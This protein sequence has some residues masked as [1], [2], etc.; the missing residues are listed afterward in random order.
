MSKFTVLGERV[1]VQLDKMQDHTVTDKG[2]VVPHFINIEASN[3]MPEAKASNLEYL[4]VGTVESIPEKVSQSTGL[5]V[6][7]RVF[8]APSVVSPSY[9]FFSKRTGLVEPFE[10][11]ILIPPAYIEAKLN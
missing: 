9:Q 7:D 8:V 1:L 6:G 11:L 4:S 3:G 2:V 5:S 10:G